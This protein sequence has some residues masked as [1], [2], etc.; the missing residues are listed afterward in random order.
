MFEENFLALKACRIELEKY[1]INSN[2]YWITKMK[3]HILNVPVQ[4]LEQAMNKSAQPTKTGARTMG[5]KVLSSFLEPHV[6]RLD[7]D[8]R[9]Q[10]KNGVIHTRKVRRLF[11]LSFYLII[12]TFLCSYIDS[13]IL[14]F[15][16]TPRLFF[17]EPTHIA[18]T[19]SLIKYAMT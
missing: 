17:F 5:V 7:P 2:F 19:V 15:R 1:I 16:H 10:F 12:I 13:L 6:Q 14:L 18:K 11:S 9:P 4:D 8:L 3:K